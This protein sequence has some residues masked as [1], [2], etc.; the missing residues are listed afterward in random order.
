M[1]RTK[2]LLTVFPHLNDLFQQTRSISEHT[3]LFVSLTHHEAEL[4]H[5]HT[6]SA[7]PHGGQDDLV[8]QIVVELLGHFE[9]GPLHS[10]GG[11]QTQ[12][13]AQATQHAEH[14]QI[15]RVTE[16]TLLQS[17]RVGVI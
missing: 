9:A 5:T 17:E 14:Q 15:P 7:A 8:E 12:D 16:A 11:G 13:N 6:L 1:G 10:H 2:V 3:H 4:Q